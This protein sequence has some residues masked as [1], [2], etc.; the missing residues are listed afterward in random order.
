MLAAKRTGRGT[1][2]VLSG[3]I[4]TT[5][6]AGMTAD[7]LVIFAFQTLYGYV[8]HWIALLIASF[9]VGLSLGGLLM[10]RHLRRV[11]GERRALLKL[12]G[13]ILLFWL[14]LPLAL[15]ALY[16]RPTYPH[17]SASIQGVLLLANAL[18]GLLVGA[19]FPLANTMWLRDTTSPTRGAGALYASDLVGAFL[20]AVLVS[21][22]LVPILGILQT[23]LL[24]A[25]LKL[26]SLLVVV[27]RY[28]RS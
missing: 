9:M 22:V 16:A 2:V 12:E 5:G 14:L 26:G 10:T 20:G 6:F 7:L 23:C 17:A 13:A 24:V 18:A 28:P 19:Q 27:V 25:A 11:E 1:S 8:Y 3:V 15:S 4:A 21:V